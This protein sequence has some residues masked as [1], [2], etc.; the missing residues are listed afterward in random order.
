VLT[1]PPLGVVGTLRVACALV[2]AERA[3]KAVRGPAKDTLLAHATGATGRGRG[4]AVHQALDQVGAVIG[5]LT[6]AESW[7]S[8]AVATTT[9]RSA[10]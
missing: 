10:R 8:P 7:C 4:L 3:G 9:C 6:V 1:V 2:I 5:P